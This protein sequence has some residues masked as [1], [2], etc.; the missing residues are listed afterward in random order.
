MF[1][2][3]EFLDNTEKLTQTRRILNSFPC[4]PR[5]PDTKMVSQEN[6]PDEESPLFA[7]AALGTAAPV[8]TAAHDITGL[9]AV[10]VATFARFRCC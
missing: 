4:F 3:R 10:Y 8:T 7:A 1:Y 6:R 2:Y 5:F 9:L